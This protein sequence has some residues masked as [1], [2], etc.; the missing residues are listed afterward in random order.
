MAFKLWLPIFLFWPFVSR[1][2]KTADTLMRK[3][4]TMR[5]LYT[6]NFAFSLYAV[7]YSP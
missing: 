5:L 6:I 3:F 2:A 7:F 1:G 4:N